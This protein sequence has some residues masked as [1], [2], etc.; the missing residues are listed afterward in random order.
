MPPFTTSAECL[1]HFASLDFLVLSLGLSAAN[2]M[3]PRVSNS[4]ASAFDLDED[5]ST[6]PP[7]VEAAGA[8]SRVD[9]AHDSAAETSSIVPAAAAPA[10][11]G[12]I[13]ETNDRPA[14][15][16]ESDWQ[17]ATANAELC[18]QFIDLTETQGFSANQAAQQLRRSASW[19]SGSGSMLARYRRSG[20]AGCLP[21]RRQAG[22]KP[23]FHVPDWFIPAA[24]FF[25]L[26]T[27]R[28]RDGGSIPEAIRR[29]AS[30]A[31]VPYGWTDREKQR[32]L[33]ALGLSALPECPQELRDT[34]VGRE[35]A[36][37]AMLPERLTRQIKVNAA[38][39]HQYRNPK[40][41][42]LDYLNAPGGMRLFR[43][44]ITGEMRL[45]RAGEIIEA[46]DATINF[47]VCVPWNRDGSD[48]KC[49]QKYRRQGGT[50]PMAREHRCRHQLR[51]RVQL[52]RPPAQ[53]VSCRGHR[54][55]HAHCGAATRRPQLQ[56]RFERGSWESNLVKDAIRHMGARLDTVYSPHQKPFIEGLFNTLWTKLSVHFP[57]RTRRPLSRGTSGG[58]SFADR[59]PTGAQGSTPIL[60]DARDGDRRL[61]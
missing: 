28:T 2:N 22:A 6:L 48:D 18:R 8:P 21:Q 38:T 53:F 27:N 47:P 13:S 60:S 46:D 57:E 7:H 32:L 4:V 41:A 9:L 30:L 54:Q 16:T 17:E 44:P 61:P 14:N 42:T 25:Y 5:V 29:A 26:I 39:V 36:G 20:V 23:S 24:R 35:K 59:L 12:I 31:A 51:H 40:N 19:F 1:S 49:V 37:Q 34:I 10:A 45:A 55:P 58:K 3:N 15:Y 11:V 52:H 56:W 43:D 50:L 33:K